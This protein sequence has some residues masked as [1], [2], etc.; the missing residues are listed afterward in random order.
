MHDRVEASG[1]YER[2]NRPTHGEAVS[3]DGRIRRDEKKGSCIWRRI[4]CR[5]RK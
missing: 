4:R 2:V 5:A 1:V 3:F